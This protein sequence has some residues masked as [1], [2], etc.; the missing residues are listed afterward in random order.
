MVE[1]LSNENDV[2]MAIDARPKCVLLF[3]APWSR[4]CQQLQ[5]DFDAMAMQCGS[6]YFAM[7]DT[8]EL[9]VNDLSS[10]PTVHI[11]V[12]GTLLGELRGPVVQCSDIPEILDGTTSIPIKGGMYSIIR[13]TGPKGNKL[14]ALSTDT[15]MELLPESMQSQ[16]AKKGLFSRIKKTAGKLRK[17]AKAHVTPMDEATAPVLP[18]VDGVVEESILATK[19]LVLGAKKMDH[20]FDKSLL[21]SPKAASPRYN[22]QADDLNKQ[23]SLHNIT[24]KDELDILTHTPNLVFV[25]YHSERKMPSREMLKFFSQ[26]ASSHEGYTFCIVDTD[27]QASPVSAPSFRAFRDGVV[28]EEVRGASNSKL[29]RMIM[30]CIE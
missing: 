22:Q 12:G 23:D 11:Y 19:K 7:V 5:P 17:P 6:A 24:N 28:V 21:A 16:P 1:V 27:S 18:H 13:S 15:D 20:R 2:R 8:E 14:R 26:S 9:V 4:A 10:V 30:E 3:Y 25:M 29:R